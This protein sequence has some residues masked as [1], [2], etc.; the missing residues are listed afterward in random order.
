MAKAVIAGYSRSPFTI[1]NKGDLVSVRPEDLL[2]EVIKDL[3]IKSKINPGAALI[4]MG[5]GYFSAGT[6]NLKRLLENLP[7]KLYYS[8]SQPSSFD[9]NDKAIIKL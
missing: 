7:K 2:A 3:V 9:W 6:D 1:A 5:G 8:D 4:T